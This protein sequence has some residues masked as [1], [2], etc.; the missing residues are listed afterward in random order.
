MTK[1][2]KRVVS[3]TEM[4]FLP[5]V[6][7]KINLSAVFVPSEGCEGNQPQASLPYLSMAVFSLCLLTL[8]SF[9]ACLCDQISPFY[10]D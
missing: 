10:K 9:Y 7:S 3:T 6:E 2:R 1:Y 8:P 4:Y 5:V